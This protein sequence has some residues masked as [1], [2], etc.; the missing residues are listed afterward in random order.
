[1]GLGAAAG[2]GGGGGGRAG[3]AAAAVGRARSARVRRPIRHRALERRARRCG[4]VAAAHHRTGRGEDEDGGRR[5]G[6]ADYP[7]QL[8]HITQP[9][10]GQ[11]RVPHRSAL[12]ARPGVLA[13]PVGPA[14]GGTHTIPARR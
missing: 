10:R 8:D 2:A 6:W 7:A 13:R 9:R 14:G 12:R 1:M 11:H 5:Q 3:N 4:A